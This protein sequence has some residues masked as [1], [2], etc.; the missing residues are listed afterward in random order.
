M[1]SEE[2]TIVYVSGGTKCNDRVYVGL[3]EQSTVVM[4]DIIYILYRVDVLN[5]MNHAC[6]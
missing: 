1:H 6:L 5:E 4:S 3:T 2:E